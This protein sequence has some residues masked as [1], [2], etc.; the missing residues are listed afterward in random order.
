ME[1]SP[2]FYIHSIYK[3]TEGEGVFIGTPQIFIRFQ[4]C[5]IGCINCDSKETW[6]FSEGGEYLDIIDLYT[7][8]LRESMGIKRVS[9]T[10]GDPMHPK[11]IEGVKFLAKF[12][13]DKGHYVNIEASG[14]RVDHELFD[15]VDYISFDFKTPSTGVKT[16]INLVEKVATQYPGKYQIKSVIQDRI[17]FEYVMEAKQSLGNQY[18]NWV[19]TPAYNDDSEFHVKDTQNVLKWNEDNAGTFRV[20]SQQHKFIY[21]T[22]SLRV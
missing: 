7:L 12:L 9:I 5:S 15:L 10:G 17:D 18:I 19:L 8:V 2:K 4:G 22:D 21:G 14:T 11:H 13:K 1:N 20:I 3:A 16:Q 6:S